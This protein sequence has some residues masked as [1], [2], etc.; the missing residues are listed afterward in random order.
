MAASKTKAAQAKTTEPSKE[1]IIKGPASAAPRIIDR[2]N[3]EAT[4]HLFKAETFGDNPEVNALVEA[5]HGKGIATKVEK[6]GAE[7]VRKIQHAHFFHSISSEGIP[8]KQ[9]NAICGHVHHV[10]WEFDKVTGYP[11]AKCG[12]A[13]K[14]V[15]RPGPGGI[16]RTT[17]EPVK[18]KHPE[19][20]TIIIDRHEHPMVYQGSH[21]ISAAKIQEIQKSN[22]EQIGPLVKP[23]MVQD[24]SVDGTQVEGYQVVDSDR[25]TAEE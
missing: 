7:K 24:K 5:V 3:I 9:T 25:A 15:V 13:M 22:A 20:G 23:G 1:M 10:T 4:H 14:K 18:M 17:W 12:P 6:Y 19:D 11:V 2:S 21:A 16:S 8:Q